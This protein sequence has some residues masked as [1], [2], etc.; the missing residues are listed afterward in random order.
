MAFSSIFGATGMML[1]AT[2]SRAIR[3]S[4]SCSSLSLN[5][6]PANDSSSYLHVI[7]GLLQ[8]LMFKLQS[9]IGF[10]S[11]KPASCKIRQNRLGNG[12]RLLVLSG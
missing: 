2:K 9:N 1:S 10:D 6:G 5:C 3:T 4:I 12:S 11:L 8:T 7:R